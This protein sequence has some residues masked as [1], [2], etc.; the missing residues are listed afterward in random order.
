LTI[1]DRRNAPA[2]N[3]SGRATITVGIHGAEGGAEHSDP[4]AGGSFADDGAIEGASAPPLTVAEVGAFHEFGTRH[5][6]QRSF[7]RAWFDEAVASGEIADLLRS[8]LKLA[9]AGKLPLDQALERVALKCQASVQKRITKRIPPPLAQS[10]IDRKGSSVP[11]IDTGQ[12]RASIR[13]RVS[14]G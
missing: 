7:I 3:L 10:T 12:L 14:R 6:P 2:P 1:T 11:L 9:V 5:I 4:L 8:Q 13:G